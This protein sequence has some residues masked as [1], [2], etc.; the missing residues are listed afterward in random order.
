MDISAVELED[1]GLQ[2]FDQRTAHSSIEWPQMGKY[3]VFYDDIKMGLFGY[4]PNT[5]LNQYAVCHNLETL[6]LNT[7]C[8]CLHSILLDY[9][10]NIYCLENS[11]LLQAGKT[12]VIY[13]R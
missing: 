12:R 1:E 10:P 13:L 6:H 8:L 9:S 5:G 4:L 2:G 3:Q 11:Q 7:P